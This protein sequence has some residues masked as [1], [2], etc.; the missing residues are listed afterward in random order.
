MTT[1]LTREDRDFLEQYHLS[2]YERPSVAVDIVA[3]ALGPIP[4]DAE[5]PRALYTLLTRRTELPQIGVA[6]LLGGFVGVDE[7]LEESVTRVL[8][9]KA[10]LGGVACEQLYT[11]GNP[12]RDPRGRIISV[13][14]LAL[15]RFTETLRALLAND[16]TLF[17][18]LKGAVPFDPASGEAIPLAFDHAYILESAISR[19]RAKLD[20]WPLRFELLPDVFTMKELQHLHETVL[21]SSV[22]K[23]SFRRRMVDSGAVIATGDVRGAV[24]RPAELYRKG[25]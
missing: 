10:G 6:S 14:Y 19:V 11:F 8:H 13:T 9:D 24:G 15:L 1:D 16:E 17:S 22:N 21:G 3:L 7:S 25:V 4:E 5:Q 2:D 20:Y 12:E 18:P 23:D